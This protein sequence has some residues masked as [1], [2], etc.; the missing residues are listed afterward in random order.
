LFFHEENVLCFLIPLEIESDKFRKKRGKMKLERASW[1]LE[2][3]YKAYKEE[4]MKLVV[5]IMAGE[6]RTRKKLESLQRKEE[7]KKKQ[8][9]RNQCDDTDR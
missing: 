5:M 4:K 1:E 9:I 2:T 8:K 3:N 6:V 7:N